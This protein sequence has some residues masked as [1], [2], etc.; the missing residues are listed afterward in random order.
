M[1]HL[2]IVNCPVFRS[3]SHFWNAS[4]DDRASVSRSAIYNRSLSTV[5]LSIEYARRMAPE[6]SQF[7]DASTKV[8]D[9]PRSSATSTI[10]R[11]CARSPI[12]F[13]S[14]CSRP[15]RSKDRSPRRRPG[16]HRRVADDVF[17]P[18]SSVGEVRLR[19]RGRRRARS[20][21]PLEI[22]NV[23]MRFSDV[24]EDPEMSVAAKSLERMVFDRAYE[25]SLE[26]H[27]DEGQFPQGLAG[28]LAER[29]DD[30]LGDAR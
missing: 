28:G 21:S 30:P 9:V 16:T 3:M 15:S 26:L 2:C 17:V 20:P 7:E 22:V 13:A 29:R 1:E 4:C 23:G 12:P 8:D 25:P 14:H 24:T 18:L 27:L 5:Y 11:R 10:P 19:R 6:R